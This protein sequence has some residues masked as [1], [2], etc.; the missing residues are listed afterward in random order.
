MIGDKMFIK[1][2]LTEMS[3]DRRISGSASESLAFSVLDMLAF[4]THELFGQPKI[5]DINP[6]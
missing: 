3:V 5:N 6:M 1:Q 4:R 2:R